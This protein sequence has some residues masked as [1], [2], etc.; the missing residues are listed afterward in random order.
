MSTEQIVSS[1]L[2]DAEEN[3]EVLE[4]SGFEIDIVDDTPEEDRGR[5]PPVDRTAKEHEEEL[6]GVSTNVQKRIKK[7][8]Y[9]FHEERRAKENSARMRD[10]AVVYAQ[11]IHKENQKLRDLVNRGEQVLVDEVKQRTEKEL[12]SAKFQLKR[13]HEEGDPD[14]IV[15]AQELLAKAAYDSQKAQEY[16][17]SPEPEAVPE[18]QPRKQVNPN[19]D[20]KAA[21]WAKENP[22]FKTDKEMTA[23]ALA[24]HEDLVTQGVDTK[25]D[26]YYQAIDQRVRDRFP[27]KFGGD[28]QDDPVLRSDENR[29][30]P[31]TV[32]AP[33][34]RTTGARPRKV[35]LTKTQVSL[36]KRLGISPEEYAKQLLKLE[37]Q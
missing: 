28:D 5:I 11:K 10:E 1:P 34:R 32:V 37:N 33:A 22:W 8:K 15:G 3:D 24:V 9:D 31:S 29:R 17:P 20:P 30:K 6:A 27:E 36:A 23:V 13:A 2:S 14:S 35:Q 19:P 21:D 12:E 7:L 18:Y 25:S 26:D 16:I 4:D